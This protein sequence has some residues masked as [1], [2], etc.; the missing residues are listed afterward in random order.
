MRTSNLANSIEARII[1]AMDNI[2]AKL[3]SALDNAV[4]QAIASDDVRFSLV[5]G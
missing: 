3:S 5:M 2:E 1:F 4:L